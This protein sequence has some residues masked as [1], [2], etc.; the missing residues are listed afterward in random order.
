MCSLAVIKSLNS[1]SGL[2]KAQ[3]PLISKVFLLTLFY[4]FNYFYSS[5]ITECND[6]SKASKNKTI[7][8]SAR[9]VLIWQTII[10]ATKSLI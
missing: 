7:Y 8:C 4:F 10:L 9:Y 6:V 3:A 1:P 5:L 2:D